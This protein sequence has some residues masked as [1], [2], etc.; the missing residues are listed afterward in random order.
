MVIFTF[1]RLY[2]PKTFIRC[3]NNNLHCTILPLVKQNHVIQH[4]TGPPTVSAATQ[5]P[6]SLPFMYII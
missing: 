3:S 1:S 6:I 5:V 2:E 4:T